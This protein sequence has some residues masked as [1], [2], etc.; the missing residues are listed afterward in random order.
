MIREL[1]FIYIDI[2]LKNLMNNGKKNYLYNLS[3]VVVRKDIYTPSISIYSPNENDVFEDISPSF[4]VDIQDANLD[5]MWYFLN[6]E[7]QVKQFTSNDTIDQ[8][9]WNNLPDGI[10]ILTFFSNDTAGNIGFSSVNIIKDT[11]LPEILILSPDSNEI[12]GENPP[13]YEISI[14]ESNLVSTWYTID[15]G[16]T[17][18]TFSGFTGI[19][20]LTAWEAALE[21][22]INITFYAQDIAGNMKTTT[23][24]VIKRFPSEMFIPGYNIYFLYGIVFIIGFLNLRKR[25]KKKETR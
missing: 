22:P 7:S 19:V 9:L 8:D 6:L 2:T 5:K 23:V 3:L 12:F 20:N 21:G 15:G 14:N 17:N 11:L 10:V 4:I 16:I 25:S 13:S 24:S 18:Y 1:I